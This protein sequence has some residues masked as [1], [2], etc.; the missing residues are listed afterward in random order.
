M[1]TN[2]VSEAG[3]GAPTALH[4][5]TFPPKHWSR[6]QCLTVV[7]IKQDY[8]ATDSPRIILQTRVTV[9]TAGTVDP[10]QNRA[11]ASYYLIG[12]S[13]EVSQLVS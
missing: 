3:R 2:F 1:I 7:D 12:A 10:F 11:V 13:L 4:W 8:P 9:V 6:D 5:L